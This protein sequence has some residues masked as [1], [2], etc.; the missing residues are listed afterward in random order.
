MAYIAKALPAQ[1]QAYMTYIVIAYIAKALPAQ[2]QAYIAMVYVAMA[3]IV[4][5]LSAQKQSLNSYG[6]HS[7]RFAFCKPSIYNPWPT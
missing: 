7:H 1:G 6:L 3:H 2:T 4:M 5:A